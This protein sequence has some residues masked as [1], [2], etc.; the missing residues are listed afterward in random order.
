MHQAAP[1]LASLPTRV[2]M[3]QSY[4]VCDVTA[5][6][7]MPA[8]AK[9]VHELVQEILVH[10]LFAALVQHLHVHKSIIDALGLVKC[11]C[12]RWKWQINAS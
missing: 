8:C 12:R 2:G 9:A 3:A 10:G 1:L 11:W 7:S 5:E 6:L 4:T